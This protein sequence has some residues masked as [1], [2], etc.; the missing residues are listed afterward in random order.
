MIKRTSSRCP[1]CGI[2]IVT[3]GS[4]LNQL[5]SWYWHRWKILFHNLR[6]HRGR[7][8]WYGVVIWTIKLPF[9]ILS[10]IIFALISSWVFWLGILVALGFLIGYYIK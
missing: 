7:I 3:R 10:E 4:H 9:M 6:Y 8:K 5:N 2:E 1:I